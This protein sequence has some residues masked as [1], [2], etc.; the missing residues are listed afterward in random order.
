MKIY[1]L[2]A[3]VVAVA[4][5][6]NNNKQYT[7][8]VPIL[9]QID[10]HNED[11]SYSYG[12]EAADGT[13]KIETKYPNGEVYG[14]YG[15]IDDAGALREVEYG[16]SRRGFEPAGN[17][18]QVAPPTLNSDRNAI[19]PLGPEEEDDGQY[20]EDPADYYKNDP[21]TQPRQ[22][23]NN[24]TPRYRPESVYRQEPDTFE[25]EIV[26]PSYRPQQSYRAQNTYR[27][28]T[29]FRPQQSY[30]PQSYYRNDP[31]PRYYEPEPQ[32]RPQPVYRP[33]SN[34]GFRNDNNNN[35]N[36]TPAPTWNNNP[37]WNNPQ[38]NGGGPSWAGN[39]A[40][41]VD[42]STGSYTVQYKR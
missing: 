3:A 33:Q 14:K 42:I 41:N 5:A 35:W 13:F 26:Q 7:T 11:G 32:P 39:P 40:Q 1:V 10:K 19:R 31:E 15:Y 21:Y 23:I 29:S 18:I 8:P 22:P 17:E 12:Y 4:A 9:K 30:K 2:A 27:P 25:P 38:P 16:A 20:R 34:F 24:P 37:T 28:Q 6:A 36:P